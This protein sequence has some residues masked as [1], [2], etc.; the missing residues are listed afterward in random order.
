MKRLFRSKVGL[1]IIAAAAIGLGV[2]GY[3]QASAGTITDCTNNS[4][5]KCGEP[6]ASAF[7]NKV[8]SNNPRDLQAIYADFGLVSSQ[9]SKF[10][11]SARPGMAYQNGTIVVDGQVVATNAWSIGRSHFSYSSPI[12]IAGH[13]YYKSMDSRVLKQNLPVMVMF[14]GKG[15]MQFA[16]MNACGNPATGNKVTPTYSCNLLHKSAVQG[17][18]NTYKFWTDASAGHNASI[19][20]VVYDFGDG[21]TATQTNPGAKVTHTYKTPGTYTAK[22]TVYVNLPGNQQIQVT[23]ATC[24]TKITVQAPPKVAFSCDSLQ[25]VASKDNDLE[26]TFQA[27]T[28]AQNATLVDADFDFGDNMTAQHVAPNANNG[29]AVSVGHTY[30]KAGT[31][32]IQA[33]VRFSVKDQSGNTKVQSTTCATKITTSVC[34]TNPNLPP[35]SPECQPC[36]YN[37][38]LPANSPK[39]IKPVATTVLPN[40]GAGDVVGLFAGASLAGFVGYR[41]FLARRLARES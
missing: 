3:H 29:T 19:A 9:Y 38:S 32:D 33:T 18:D 10:V 24:K 6:S 4:I 21:T 27:N 23:S 28:S 35:N 25:A 40:T 20:K 1:A 2:F 26:Y 17:Q 7:I 16:V 37:S 34:S 22:V 30:A 31:Y 12:T 8:K 36:K 41:L 15:V 11:S 14:D 5:I 13:T 39:C